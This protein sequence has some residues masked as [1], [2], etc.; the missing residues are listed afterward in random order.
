MV[1]ASRLLRLQKMLAVFI[2]FR[3]SRRMRRPERSWAEIVDF[4]F[5]FGHGFLRPAQVRSEIR[6]ALEII[7]ASQP[8]VVVEIGTAGGGNFFLLS[9]AAQRDGHLV[10]VDLPSGRWGEGYQ[11]WKVPIFKR[12]LVR[13]QRS[14]FIRAD[15]HDA[16]TVNEV[17]RVLQGEPVDVLFIDGD[18]SYEGV[19]KDFD[20]YSTL[21]RRGGL[22]FF[23]DIVRHPASA[24]C[25]VDRLWNELHHRYES[26]EFVEN[27]EQG[28]GGIGLIRTPV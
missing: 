12:L 18:H 3:Q 1:R 5:T 20:L 28:W 22:V 23:H 2:E 19:K 26:R 8:K 10:S 9:R 13:G 21:V 24:D 17:V 6:Q 4:A 14:H 11:V 25:H 27:I 16:A 7:E 15:S